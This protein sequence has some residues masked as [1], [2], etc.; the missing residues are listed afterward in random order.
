MSIHRRILEL[1]REGGVSAIASAMIRFVAWREYKLR[2]WWYFNTI[3]D[4]TE[5]YRRLM[6]FRIRRFGPEESVGGFEDEIGKLQF[7]FLRQK[8]LEESDVLLDLGCGVLRGGRY[9]IKYLDNNNYIGMDISEQ[10]IKQGKDLIDD[11]LL[12]RKDPI[13]LINNDLTFKEINKDVDF[14]IAQ[15]V[16]SHLPEDDIKE[17]FENVS[18]ILAENGVFYATFLSDEEDYKQR[19][20]NY[21][22]SRG[23]IKELAESSDLNV[24]FLPNEEYP[25]PYNQRMMEI[26]RK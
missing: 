8:G 17:C 10:A 26:K 12:H 9:Y 14:I 21:T 24:E 7:D 4:S 15:S 25:H 5:A 2:E 11:E 20:K 19:Q 6:A 23:H 22:Y 16:F 3:D 13:F 1:Y 18:D